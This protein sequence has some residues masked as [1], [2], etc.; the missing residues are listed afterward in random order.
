MNGKLRKI[1]PLALSIAML[2]A[3]AAL[4]GDEKFDTGAP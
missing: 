3:T 2:T 4:A 1:S